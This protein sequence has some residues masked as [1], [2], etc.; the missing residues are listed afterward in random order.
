MFIEPADVGALLRDQLLLVRE[1]DAGRVLDATAVQAPGALDD[2]YA[3]AEDVALG[4][5]RTTP[6]PGAEDFATRFALWAPTAQAVAVCVYAD[7]SRGNARML[8][9]RRDDAT[10]VWTLD[11]PGTLHG[12]RYAYLVDVIVPG[13]GLVRNRVTDPYSC[14]LY[15][16]RCV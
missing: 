10:G 13:V 5:F 7:A 12:T 8:P 1:D 3:A 4:A 11:L 15:T 6:P 14:L 9:A 16:S 2:L